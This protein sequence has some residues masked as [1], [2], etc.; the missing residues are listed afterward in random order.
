MN[1]LGV[2]VYLS[3]LVI[4]EASKKHE[5]ALERA[6]LKMSVCS[7]VV[8]K[9]FFSLFFFSHEVSRLCCGACKGLGRNGE[10]G[11]L[12]SSLLFLDVTFLFL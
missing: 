10:T 11:N 1:Y 7:S 2:M 6:G 12:G 3:D 5:V 9:D 4:E 8:D